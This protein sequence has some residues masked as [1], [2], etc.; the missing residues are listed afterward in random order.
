MT[1]MHNKRKY[2]GEPIKDIR[3]GDP[4][5]LHLPPHKKPKIWTLTVRWTETLTREASKSFTSKASRDEARVRIARHFLEEANRMKGPKRY[6]YWPGY[7]NSPLHNFEE[8]ERK[9][10][11]V[12]P[13]Y[14]E[15]YG[16]MPQ[17]GKSGEQK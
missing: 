11:K 9:E 10:I 12:G 1:D 5:P 14:I 15:G 16:D 13:E 4:G 3:K 2:A 8:V 17:V 6:R 7:W